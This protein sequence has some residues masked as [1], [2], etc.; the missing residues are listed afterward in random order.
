MAGAQ[1]F[2]F[3][4]L[5]EGFG[6]PVLEAM[7]CGTP[8][9]C[10]NNSSLAEIAGNAALLIDPHSEENIS[11]GLEKLYI[12]ETLR[13]ELRGKGLDRIMDFS[14]GKSSEALYAVYKEVSGE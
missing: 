2:C 1:F 9:L 5:Y 6:M 3:P 11:A 10:A 4:S 7:A 12:D 13:T 8:V 14:W